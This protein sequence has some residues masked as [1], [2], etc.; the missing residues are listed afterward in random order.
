MPVRRRQNRRRATL[1]IPAQKWLTGRATFWGLIK[2][3]EFG[4]LG[5]EWQDPREFWAQHRQWALAEAQRLGLP[6]PWQEQKF[7]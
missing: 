3:A 6:Q 5:Y 1:S 2:S 4:W 7:I